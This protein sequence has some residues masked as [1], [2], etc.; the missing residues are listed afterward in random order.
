VI[1][2]ALAASLLHWAGVT[3]QDAAVVATE[4]GRVVLIAGVG[5]LIAAFVEDAIH[6]PRRDDA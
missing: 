3:P 1:A 6:G 2:F 4:A 5:W